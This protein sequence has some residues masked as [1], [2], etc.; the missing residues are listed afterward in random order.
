MT[1]F[2]FES[3]MVTVVLVPPL[4]LFQRVRSLPR[5]RRGRVLNLSSACRGDTFSNRNNSQDTQRA[6][7]KKL[8]ELIVEVKALKW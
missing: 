4:L 2:A 5:F 3:K 8:Q 6:T 1:T 7:S